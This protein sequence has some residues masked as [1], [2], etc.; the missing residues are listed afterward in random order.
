MLT[1]VDDDFLLPQQQW[2]G[3]PAQQLVLSRL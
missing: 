1:K 2:L 3:E